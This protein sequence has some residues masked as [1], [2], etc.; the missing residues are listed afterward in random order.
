MRKATGDVNREDMKSADKTAER[1]A[2][3]IAERLAQEVGAADRAAL[4]SG[5]G[6]YG[7]VG[8]RTSTRLQAERAL[9]FG[10]Q[11]SDR[12]N[13]FWHVGMSGDSHGRLGGYWGSN[14]S[15]GTGG[16]SAGTDRWGL[17]A[18]GEA[19]GLSRHTSETKGSF[20]HGGDR[21]DHGN[22]AKNATGATLRSSLDSAKLALLERSVT[23]PRT[24]PHDDPTMALLNKASSQ[25]WHHLLN[26]S[27]SVPRSPDQPASSGALDSKSDMREVI[28]FDRWVKNLTLTTPRELDE[29]PIKRASAN[30]AAPSA[31]KAPPAAAAAAPALPAGINA[32]MAWQV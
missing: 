14:N 4:M 16:A 22:T 1:L 13:S 20:W 9:A 26:A 10:M 18:S 17:G 28:E 31:V 3:R 24:I 11:G 15:I 6:L 27:P 2:D 25:L 23:S 30:A 32:S 8:E 21:W 5:I 29:S 19:Y 7:S 12:S